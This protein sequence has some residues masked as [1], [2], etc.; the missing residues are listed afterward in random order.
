LLVEQACVASLGVKETERVEPIVSRQSAY[1]EGREEE[2]TK[3]K[4]RREGGVTA[5]KEEWRG[6]H[7]EGKR[8][9][10]RPPLFHLALHSIRHEAKSDAMRDVLAQTKAE[11]TCA[12]TI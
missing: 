11:R 10:S 7:R 1:Q 3:I 5:G 2:G 9:S 12:P 6:K 4:G 8:R